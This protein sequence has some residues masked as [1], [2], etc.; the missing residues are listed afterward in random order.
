MFCKMGTKKRSKK[1]L[2]TASESD[3]SN[4][5][6]KTKLACIVE[7]HESTMRRLE[8]TPPKDHEI[9]SRRKAT[10]RKVIALENLPAWQLDKVMSKK[11]VILEAQRRAKES[12]L[13]F[14][15]GHLSSQKNAELEP[16]VP[17]S[18]CGRNG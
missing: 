12:Q 15:D 3:E 6:Q 1:L 2:E 8:P 18:Q 5:T 9:T 4:K 16:K 14:F 13:C 10:I 7:A 17:S 11:D